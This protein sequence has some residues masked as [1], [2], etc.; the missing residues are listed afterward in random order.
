MKKHVF[1]S[2]SRKDADTVKKLCADLER[3]GYVLWLDEDQ[4]IPGQNWELEIQKAIRSA[5]G[6]LICLSSNWVN[7]RGY[8]QK[9]LKQ[10][11][12]ILNEFPEGAIF[13]VPVKLDTCDAPR[14]LGKIHW[15]ALNEAHGY[16]SLCKSLSLLLHGE[17]KTVKQ[18]RWET[19]DAWSSISYFENQDSLTLLYK[20]QK[21]E[22]HSATL[23]VSIE[24]VNGKG[25]L[26]YICPSS[27]KQY[28]N[29]VW[30][31]VDTILRKKG[32]N[33]LIPLLDSIQEE[34]SIS[35]RLC[36]CLDSYAIEVRIETSE[37]D[38][39]ILSEYLFKLSISCVMLAIF[40][41]IHLSNEIAIYIGMFSE[42]SK[43]NYDELYNNFISLI[44]Q[45]EVKYI[46]CDAHMKVP[47]QIENRGI[48]LIWISLPS[49]EANDVED[50]LLWKQYHSMFREY[51]DEKS[52]EKTWQEDAK[53]YTAVQV[54]GG[55]VN[56]TR[57]MPFWRDEPFS[58]AEPIDLYRAITE[59]RHIVILG[60]PGT[61]KT[62]SLIVF[63]YLLICQSLGKGIEVTNTEQEIVSAL[64]IP[65][66]PVY[67]NMRNYDTN[68][69]NFEEFVTVPIKQLTIDYGIDYNDLLKYG[70]FIF[71]IDSINEL[72]VENYDEIT[73]QI[74]DF[75]ERYA[76]NRF[77][78]AS[79]RINYSPKAL[80]VSSI[81]LIQNLDEKRQW[82][83]LFNYLKHYFEIDQIQDL[84]KKINASP[85]LRSLAVNPLHLALI[86]L[87]YERAKTLPKTR[88]ELLEDFLVS[89][90]EWGSKHF[91]S[92][93]K[94]IDILSGLALYMVDDL[95]GAVHLERE[96]V[97]TV[98]EAE[99][100][101]TC[102]DN[103]PKSL[104]HA[105]ITTGQTP[106]E[107]LYYEFCNKDILRQYENIHNGIVNV[108]V[109]FFHQTW[110]EF[111]AG[112]RFVELYKDNI[113][114][115]LKERLYSMSWDEAAIL[116]VPYLESEDMKSIFVSLAQ[117]DMQ[118]LMQCYYKAREE[119]VDPTSEK[120][121]IDELVKIAQASSEV[122]AKRRLAIE[123][124]A[125]MNSSHAVTGLVCLITEVEVDLKLF[126]AEVSAKYR[127]P[128]ATEIVESVCS[129]TSKENLGKAVICLFK[130]DFKKG[131]EAVSKYIPVHDSLASK[132]ILVYLLKKEDIISL[133]GTE[134][135]T[136]ID[137]LTRVIDKRKSTDAME[138]IHLLNRIEQFPETITIDFQK[139]TIDCIDLLSSGDYVERGEAQKSLLK[140]AEIYNP[141]VSLGIIQSLNVAEACL[142]II[143][144][145]T[146]TELSTR[147]G[148]KTAFAEDLMNLIITNKGRL[149]WA[150]AFAFSILSNPHKES[151]KRLITLAKGHD[152]YLAARCL[153]A[154][155]A[156][157]DPEIET[158]LFRMIFQVDAEPLSKLHVIQN[159]VEAF[160]CELFY[161][162]SRQLKERFNEVKVSISEEDQYGANIILRK[163]NYA[164]FFTG[165]TL[166]KMLGLTLETKWPAIAY[167]IND[168]AVLSALL[169]SNNDFDRRVALM[170][171]AMAIPSS[172]SGLVF[173]KA[174]ISSDQLAQY[175]KS[176]DDILDLVSAIMV[177]G[178]L[179]YK[180]LLPILYDWLEAEIDDMPPNHL[181]TSNV[182]R[183]QLILTFTIKALGLLKEEESILPL[184][185]E[186]E[187]GNDRN[188]EEIAKALNSIGP[189]W[190]ALK[191][192]VNMFNQ[193][194]PSTAATISTLIGKV[195]NKETANLLYDIA[196]ESSQPM[197]K[198]N[199]AWEALQQIEKRIRERIGKSADK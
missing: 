84:V 80:D 68:F 199:A 115:V 171:L 149:G 89:K 137:W 125:Q 169:K 189:H 16:K 24:S 66:F 52:L 21:N 112:R 168:S 87:R 144:E 105:A 167:A 35:Y 96:K 97:L 159:E 39:S 116:I 186:W 123:M 12:E 57:V 85:S 109:A 160:L 133:R 148:E 31:T 62:W 78:F 25:Y 77:V 86:A 100:E 22:I 155:S 183:R 36:T 59:N 185:R 175:L 91:S 9:E 147:E 158:Q 156:T 166:E 32:R 69:T 41:G 10:L 128:Q 143:A 194:T 60:D 94:V 142:A 50:F 81:Y 15:V 2:Y 192:Y 121:I 151:E 118:L 101:R 176:A 75:K 73:R 42:L 26:T 38:K 29:N 196:N 135:K 119:Y 64:T 132:T 55:N 131:L 163:L 28:M 108:I 56:V 153:F 30:Q 58:E 7:D 174:Y 79:R 20:S 8:V 187:K 44:G 82:I 134:L 23:S 184:A 106:S 93:T 179:G 157:K 51:L 92:T 34:S 71:L 63:S 47:Y 141:G 70:C 83:L 33:G 139:V 170:Y 6:A 49:F 102:K 11:L 146:K 107:I 145:A 54:K 117:I 99:L 90:Y 27:W 129:G 13:L 14:A 74:R 173:Y 18:A 104:E 43:E 61:G 17:S 103:L 198:R 193:C 172:T 177:A 161:A 5:A 76:G 136:F 1:V 150:A 48:P 127:L 122:P 178:V 40:K 95:K 165:G 138:A 130:I 154:I 46:L 19:I 162:V 98:I 126:I 111:L 190:S 152:K 113:S 124:L 197:F 45:L 65:K 140:F 72:P 110:E 195:G 3:E 114:K 180:D 191:I 53:L 88:R 182:D 188:K 4:I 181:R 164:C 37:L 67:I 120:A